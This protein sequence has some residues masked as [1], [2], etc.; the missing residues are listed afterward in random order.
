MIDGAE[1]EIG[2]AGLEHCEAKAA[3]LIDRDRDYRNVFAA[4]ELPEAAN[5]LRPV[6]PGH[7]VVGDDE[8]R[9]RVADGRQRF[10]RVAER[11]HADVVGDRRRELREDVAVRHPVVEDHHEGHAAATTPD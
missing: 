7:L 9:N 4:V 8:I 1:E 3:L 10:R 5:E 11:L 6:H 2:R